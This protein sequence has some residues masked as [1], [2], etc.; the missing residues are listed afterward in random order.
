MIMDTCPLPKKTAIDVLLH[1]IRLRIVRMFLG[2]AELTARDV[3]E[4]LD[5]VPQATLYRHLKHLAD[6]GALVVTSETP[7]RGALE[8]TY[9]LDPKTGKVPPEDI[10][11]IDPE[12]HLN[13]FSIF[14]ASLLEDFGRYMRAENVDV[15]RDDVHYLQMTFNAAPEEFA[16]FM[17]EL[18]ALVERMAERGPAKS[19]VQRTLSI[20]TLPEKPR[21]AN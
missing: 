10:A 19:R 15:V 21:K 7:V 17:D 11:A 20:V 6:A 4:M 8:R 5:D 2:D 16:G 13:Y 9:R 1:P 12:T 18:K 3:A 14:L